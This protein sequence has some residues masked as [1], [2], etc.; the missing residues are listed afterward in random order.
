MNKISK[1]DI[2]EL[3]ISII[4]LVVFA[5]FYV[6]VMTFHRYLFLLGSIYS[7]INI[8]NIWEDISRCKKAKNF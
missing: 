8:A 3:V 6:L 2:L 4:C 7:S 1:I 5:V